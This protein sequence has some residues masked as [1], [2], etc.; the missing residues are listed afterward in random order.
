MSSTE[1]EADCPICCNDLD[2]TDR[3]IQYC[4]CGCKSHPLNS[5]CAF[6]ASTTSYNFPRAASFIF[7]LTSL[8]CY[9][10]TFLQFNHAYGVITISWKKPR[11]RVYPHGA[12]I[13]GQSTTKIKSQCNTLTPNNLKKKN[14]N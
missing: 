13:A 14:E 5:K 6:V 9:Y 12:L 7:F 8:T 10:F 1:E 2:L 4:A 11:K 3:S